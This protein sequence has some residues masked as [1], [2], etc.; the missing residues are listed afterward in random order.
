MGL[1]ALALMAAPAAAH[2]AEGYAPG[3]DLPPTTPT[4]SGVL[5]PSGDPAKVGTDALGGSGVPGRGSGRVCSRSRGART[6]RYLR[7]G[8]LTKTC[9]K[10][11]GRREICRR[12]F[13]GARS[14]IA[15]TLPAPAASISVRTDGG[16][17][18]PPIRP[19]G[20]FY[21]TES[22]SPVQG[23][24]SGTLIKRGLVLTAA[25]CLYD[26]DDSGTEINAHPNG[27]YARDQLSFIPGSTVRSGQIAA[28]DG[29]WEIANTFV[30][31]GYTQNIG[32][33]DW[34]IAVLAPNRAGQYPGD[35]T[36]TFPAW[37][38]VSI[39]PGARLYS[40]GYPASGGFNTSEYAYGSWQYF[41]DNTWDGESIS[42]DN[43]PTL[44]S[45]FWIVYRPCEMNG[46]SSGGPVFVQ[47]PDK[48]W[49]IIAVNNR[50]SED[51]SGL[52]GDKVYKSYF[53]GQFIDFYNGVIA[54]ISSRTARVS[55]RPTSA[56]AAR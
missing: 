3:F 34:G 11:R 31:T 10:R 28:P 49:N 42:G 23:W 2:G 24:C 33:L 1:A 19:V 44:R 55:T 56:T 5:P 37:A 32:G 41:C 17:S 9:V 12:T 30:P 51:A 50:G 25:H 35:F 45:A 54:N 48:T 13:R 6:C 14:A 46:G 22:P 40:V 18:N 15:A 43:D 8:R 36:G 47:F 29:V 20:R 16:F 21:F 38:G 4:E 7:N 39:R 52:F 26:N 27:F 53:D